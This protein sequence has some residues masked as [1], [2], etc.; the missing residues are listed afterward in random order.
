MAAAWSR[1]RSTAGWKEGRDGDDRCRYRRTLD[2]L[3]ASHHI[4]ARRT[5]WR[6]EIWARYLSLESIINAG[7][8]ATGVQSAR[9][10]LFDMR[11]KARARP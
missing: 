11:R 5:C 9:Q 1:W 2:Y 6:L 4:A 10:S 8:A 3:T 7:H